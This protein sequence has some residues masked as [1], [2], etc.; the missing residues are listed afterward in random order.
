MTA[1]KNNEIEDKPQAS[2]IPFD[3]LIEILEPAY[4]EGILKYYRESWRE[5]FHTTTMMDST[6][7]HLTAHFYAGED[8]D[9]EAKKLGINKTHLGG[10]IFSILCMAQ[11]MLVYPELDNRP[12]KM[13]KEV[14]KIE[15]T[16]F[17]RPRT[18]INKD[19][20]AVIFEKGCV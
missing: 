6:L 18:F 8:F 10:A 20:A 19:D 4:R 2:L 12:G 16:E 11:T 15:V 3:L 7:R 5:G 13:K 1:P 14:E 17:G 9:P